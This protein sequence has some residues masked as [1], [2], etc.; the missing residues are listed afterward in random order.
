[1]VNLYAKYSR[2]MDGPRISEVGHVT[3]SSPHW[4]NLE[5]LSLVALMVN[6][7]A[8]FEV[9]IPNRSRVIEGVAKFEHVGANQF[10]Q[11]PR[12]KSA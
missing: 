3:P 9:S 4:P 11:Q 7:H 8:K 6:M 2:D 1:V 5:F 12:T 10:V